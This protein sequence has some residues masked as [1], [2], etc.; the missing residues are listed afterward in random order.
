M[1]GVLLIV[2]FAVFV[3]GAMFF[4]PAALLD[5]LGWFFGLA[6]IWLPVVLAIF[7]WRLW[8]WYIR[9]QYIANNDTVVLE[10]RIPR[11]IEKSPKAMEAVFDG[12]HIGIGETTFINRWIEGRVRAWFSFELASIGGRIHF[13]I[14]TPAFF[15]D[16]IEAQIYAQYPEV[17]IYEV[18]DYTSQIT[19]DPKV[20]DLWGCDFKKS[21]KDVLPIKTYVDYGLDKDPKEEYKIDPIAHLFEYLSTIKE[22]EQAWMQIIVRTNKDELRK[23][24]SLFK[25]E[26]R[27]K[28][29]AQKTVDEIRE[30]ARVEMQ[31]LSDPS[32]TIRGEASLMP[33]DKEKIEAIYRG[34]AKKAFDV[35]I[36]ALHIG[37]RGS[38]RGINT[39]GL[40]GVFK[41]FGS[42]NLNGIS[43]TR[44]LAAFSYPWEDFRNIRKEMRKKKIVDAYK[45]RSWFHAPYETK[46]FAM[47][48]EELATIYHFPSRAV[49][50]P[51]LERI[52]ATKAGAPPNLPF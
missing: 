23:K 48:A 27:W 44:W 29:E 35:G 40:I 17:E 47:T 22:G 30:A 7:F 9:A 50:A 11:D 41:Q 18:E 4:A 26:K 20:H 49:A 13:Y 31:S 5:V 6:P 25:K 3:I 14:W 16:I 46:W 36:R 34:Q 21:E 32:V 39:V 12:L 37:P 24:G 52:P 28:A 51:G 43:P 42:E 10:V 45:R 38:L 15:K 8:I 19:Y 1:K 2:L 33:G